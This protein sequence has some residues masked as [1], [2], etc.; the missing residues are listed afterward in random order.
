MSF[1][2]RRSVK[3]H[4]C[5]DVAGFQ[6]PYSGS[7]PNLFQ[8]TNNYN[9][10][11]TNN[12]SCVNVNFNLVVKQQNTHHYHNAIN[13]DV[14]SSFTNPITSPP[15]SPDSINEIPAVSTFIKN[16]DALLHP[17]SPPIQSYSCAP[18]NGC[19]RSRM[20]SESELALNFDQRRHTS[21]PS[22]AAAANLDK[23][24]A[25][26]NAYQRSRSISLTTDR[27]SLPSTSPNHCQSPNTPFVQQPTQ[28][29]M[30]KTPFSIKT[31]I[32]ENSSNPTPWLGN[33]SFANEL[34]YNENV[35][36]A[37]HYSGEFG[38][39]KNQLNRPMVSGPCSPLN[40]PIVP[41]QENFLPLDQ[42]E[43]GFSC[44]AMEGENQRQSN[45]QP[46][47]HQHQLNFP[48]LVDPT[49]QEPVANPILSQNHFQPQHASSVIEN[50]LRPGDLCS[51]RGHP[52][53]R[54][55]VNTSFPMA[56]NGTTPYRP[57]FSRRNNPDLEKKRIHKCNHSG[58]YL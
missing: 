12:G 57:R 51:R 4:N 9:D 6:D 54:M 14:T 8:Q 44:P 39:C 7:Q 37:A 52:Y 42:Y 28:Q 53:L 16:S 10:I 30:N 1:E 5:F 17:S 33:R 25:M 55:A 3:S 50:R 56:V 22:I 45:V 26:F 46:F 40:D 49:E 27:C 38:L 2:Q 11:E 18:I 36:P 29:A 47:F 58:K 35:F 34:S 23:R 24:E 13:Q 31:E 43:Q 20:A 32:T 21:M 19:L 15:G 41:K 48:P